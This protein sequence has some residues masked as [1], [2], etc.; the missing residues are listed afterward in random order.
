MNPRQSWSVLVS[1]DSKSKLQGKSVPS[2]WQD[3]LIGRPTRTIARGKRV[4]A[5]EKQADYNQK[6]GKRMI[7]SQSLL[8]WSLQSNKGINTKNP[9]KK[10]R[11]QNTGRDTGAGE[12]LKE[13]T[14][15]CEND[16]IKEK[17][18]CEEP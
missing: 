17:L 18:I 14:F 1:H 8:S 7:K 4:V 11:G 12:L 16:C 15:S 10:T 6:G 5:K 2:S 13:G 3:T 9:G